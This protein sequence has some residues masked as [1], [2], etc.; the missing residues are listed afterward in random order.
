[1]RSSPHKPLPHHYSPTKH[2]YFC[3]DLHIG[4]NFTICQFPNL[5]LCFL[6]VAFLLSR[7]YW[8]QKTLRFNSS[9]WV[10]VFFGYFIWVLCRV[11]LSCTHCEEMEEGEHDAFDQIMWFF[12]WSGES[13]ATVFSIVAM[14]HDLGWMH[15]PSGSACRYATFFLL[16]ICGVLI[17][18]VFIDAHENADENLVLS[19][20]FGFLS[21]IVNVQMIIFCKMNNCFTNRVGKVLIIISLLN[22]VES[23]MTFLDIEP[24]PCLQYLFQVIEIFLLWFYVFWTRRFMSGVDDISASMVDEVDSIFQNLG[25]NDLWE[26]PLTTTP[27]RRLSPSHNNMQ[28]QTGGG[29]S[30]FITL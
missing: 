9:P 10:F 30:S 4:P 28:I 8:Y 3:V 22:L 18:S 11:G 2:R 1:M 27:R 7:L 29:E 23:V 13:L 6:T 17:H 16:I 12:A 14:R 25:D 15:W 24:S 26:S 20:F 5:L 21:L 19:W